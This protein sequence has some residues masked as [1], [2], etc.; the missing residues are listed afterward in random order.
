MVK[1]PVAL[2]VFNRPDHTVRVLDVLRKVKP[3]LLIVNADGPRSHMPDDKEK[4]LKVRALIETID[5]DCEVIKNYSEINL[6]SFIR[7]SSGLDFTFKIVEEA[8]ILEDDCIP[9]VTFFPFCEQLLD[10]FKED[11]RISV[12][13]GFN[14]FCRQNANESYFFSRYPMTWGWATWRRTWQLVDMNMN[15]WP[16]F[17]STALKGVVPEYWYRREWVR[18]FDAIHQKKRPNGWDY[19]LLLT[20]WMN[21]MVAITPNISLIENIGFGMDATHPGYE[22]NHNARV[23]KKE[24]KFPLTHPVNIFRNNSMDKNVE[25]YH[26]GRSNCHLALLSLLQIISA[27]KFNAIS[28]VNFFRLSLKMHSKK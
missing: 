20:G 6:G 24:I 21:N 7:N 4:C 27:I 12:I 17:K 10:R 16:E 9:H 25:R 3:K 11:E 8:I 5:W 13:G 15:G 26:L 28:A 19:Q 1:T 22:K 14:S 18:I 2:H 23:V